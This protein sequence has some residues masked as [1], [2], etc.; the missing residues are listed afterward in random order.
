MVSEANGRA[1]E[2]GVKGV[3]MIE[4]KGYEDEKEN[5]NCAANM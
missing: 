1:C 2:S 5:R 4:G 3:R